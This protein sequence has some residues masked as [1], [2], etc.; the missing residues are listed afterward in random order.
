MKPKRLEV[1]IPL[2]NTYQAIPLTF[3]FCFVVIF[4]ARRCV[5]LRDKSS[6]LVEEARGL[7]HFTCV[8]AYVL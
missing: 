3:C 6:E 7:V 4:F 2:V 8:L 1:N 5:T